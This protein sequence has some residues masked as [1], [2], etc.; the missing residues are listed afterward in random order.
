[1]DQKSGKKGIIEETAS[2]EEEHKE[3]ITHEKR[4]AAGKKGAATRWAR[5]HQVVLYQFLQSIKMLFT[6]SINRVLL[7][8]RVGVKNINS[9]QKRERIHPNQLMRRELQ[10]ERKL[11]PPE[12]LVLK[13]QY[14]QVS[15]SN[16]RLN[17]KKC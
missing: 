9:L 1:M 11:L 14:F 12:G 3:Q 8:M 16:W 2:S 5:A 6:I 13:K 4:S 17:K 15:F 7:K 10:Q